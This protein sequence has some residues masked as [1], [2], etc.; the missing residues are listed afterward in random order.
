MMLTFYAW[1]SVV[2]AVVI[3]GLSPFVLRHVLWRAGVVDVPNHR[4]SHTQPTVRGGGV[5][6]LLA[7]VIGGGMGATALGGDD[8]LILAMV[9]AAGIGVASVGLVEDVKGLPVT[10]RLIFQL[11]IGALLGVITV[12]IFDTAWLIAP[13]S[14]FFFAAYVNF[15]NFMDGVN[16]LS[17]VHAMMAGLAFVMVGIVSNQSWLV[18][19]GLITGAV[20]A[21]FLPWNLRPPRMFLGDVG[22]YLLGGLVAALSIASFASGNS[23]LTSVAPLVIYL[24]DTISTLLRRAM[25][26]DPLFR[27]HRQHVYQRLSDAGLSHIAVALVVGAFTLAGSLVGVLVACGSINALTGWLV[28]SV[29]TAGYLILPRGWTRRGETLD[30]TSHVQGGGRAV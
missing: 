5:A 26:G 19:S 29:V 1:S 10:T 7:V 9:T 14:M 24:A 27:P 23:M 8:G 17:S 4:S 16:A 22:S 6:Q 20:F 30:Q 12:A 21:V 3:A 15:A 2:A 25:Q 11:I 18:L 13:L 28:L